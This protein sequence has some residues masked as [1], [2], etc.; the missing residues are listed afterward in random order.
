[1]PDP[2]NSAALF[3][4][5][6]SSRPAVLG[7]GAAAA[8]FLHLLPALAL[9]LLCLR[10][11]ELAAGIQTGTAPGAI[12]LTAA[13]AFG[14]DLVNLGR[15]LPGLFIFSLPFLLL[16]PR[17]RGFLCLGLAWSLLVLVYF[18]LIQFFLTARVPLGSDLYAYSLR[19]IRTTLSGGTG[20]NMK[21]L[22]GLALALAALW[23]LLLR[24]DRRSGEPLSPRAAAAVLALGLL[25][26]AFTPGRLGYAS[27]A[28]EDTYNLTRNKAAFFFDESF[29]Y[30]L[31]AGLQR[32][33]SGPARPASPAGAAAFRYLDPAYPFLRSE[34]TPDVLEPHFRLNPGNPPNLVFLLVEGLGRAFS[35][36]GANL[37]SFTPELD[38]LAENSLYWD[39]FSAVQGRTFAVLPSIFGSLP[40][41]ASDF[42]DLGK[43]MPPHNSLLSVLK[44]AGYRLKFYCGFDLDFENMRMF[45]ERQGVDTLVGEDGFGKQYARS[46]GWGYADNELVSRALSGEAADARQPF[47]SIIKTT[48]MHTPYTFKGQAEYSAR[49]EK[50]LDQLGVAEKQKDAYRAFRDIYTSI[51][52]ADAAMARF[53]EESKKNP[54]WKN[55]IFIVAGDHRLPEIPVSSRLDRYHVPFFIFSPLLK[56]PA[57]MKSV[58]SHFDIAP[59]L[60]AFF[61]KNYGIRTPLDVT[62]LGS[63]LDMEPSFRNIH[64]FPIKQGKTSLV[65][66]VSGTWFL[67]QDE[68]YQ[69]TDGMEISLSRDAA[70]LARVKAQ[71]ADFRAANDKFAAGLALLPPGAT[72][73]MG[74]YSEEAR[75]IPPAAESGGEA[76]PAVREVRSPE[77]AQAGQLTIEIIFENSGR[78]GTE[79][80][81]PLVILMSPDGREV[82]E[83][84]GSKIKLE[85]GETV[86]VQLRIKSAGVPPGRYFLAVR[87]SHPE[88]GRISGYGRY[89]IPVRLHN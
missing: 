78:T 80:F 32:A 46:N 70:A 55:T 11:A 85:A 9:A 54:A 83:S 56:A 89:R 18:S 19:D 59:S 1:M 71:F 68:L 37:G 14:M 39:N 4:S 82:S 58:S 64:S 81:V 51:L 49:F 67:N 87:P 20:L 66:F 26:L 75:R 22:A 74:L 38:K 36:P 30:F 60:L 21:V 5:R 77:V 33:D 23:S 79:T 88:T 31:P 42:T 47:V 50:R 44:G 34:Q 12:A 16:R 57:R 52:Y 35:G 17:R 73:Q 25:I 40:F 48:T 84:Y 43:R 45:L 3:F 29:A 65:E 15:Y 6:L 69:L 72:G 86:P 76:I 62:W 63:G 41:G 2:E 13:I 53:V 8:R 27:F 10:A 61:S 28:S 7:F 24:L